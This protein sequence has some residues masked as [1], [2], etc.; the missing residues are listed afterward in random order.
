MSLLTALVEELE[1]RETQSPPSA[2]PMSLRDELVLLEKKAWEK[3]MT[4]EKSKEIRE[5]GDCDVQVQTRIA[6]L[7]EWL[8]A[9]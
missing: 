9:R 7:H 2:P 6:R 4:P 1:T 5:I 3:G 8:G